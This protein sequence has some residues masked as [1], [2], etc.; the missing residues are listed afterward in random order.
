MVLDRF[1]PR[2]HTN[3]DSWALLI[4]TIIFLSFLNFARSFEHESGRRF[5]KYMYNVCYIPCTIV[6]I[7]Q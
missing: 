4:H 1:G 6:E 5:F 7:Q 2:L 3:K